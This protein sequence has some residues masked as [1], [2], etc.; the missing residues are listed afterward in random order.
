MD[1]VGGWIRSCTVGGGRGWPDGLEFIKSER[2]H[3]GG[4]GGSDGPGVGGSG[5]SS[6]EAEDS[7]LWMDEAYK[8]PV[9][10]HLL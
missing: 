9:L 7:G 6:E 3:L 2:G 5:S 4:V 8:C 10:G 1:L